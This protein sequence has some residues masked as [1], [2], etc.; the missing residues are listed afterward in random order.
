MVTEAYRAQ[1][2]SCLARPVAYP[3][4]RRGH[5]PP[6]ISSG[7]AILPRTLHESCSTST[8]PASVEFG[9]PIVVTGP[10]LAAITMPRTLGERVTQPAGTGMPQPVIADPANRSRTFLV[11]PTGIIHGACMNSSP[12]QEFC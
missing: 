8:G 9:H 12:P 6:R 7:T 5:R 1:R 2:I 4:T 10:R 3:R 11:Y